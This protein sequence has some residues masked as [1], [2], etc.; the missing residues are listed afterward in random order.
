MQK[1][2]LTT[3]EGPVQLFPKTTYWLI[4]T[5]RADRLIPHSCSILKLN[6]A[7]I[8]NVNLVKNWRRAK[9]L[10]NCLRRQQLPSKVEGLTKLYWLTPSMN[11]KCKNCK[12]CNLACATLPPHLHRDH[13]LLGT[14]ATGDGC[15]CGRGQ[16]QEPKALIWW[17]VP[18]SLIRHAN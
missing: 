6:W 14:E 17:H 15:G 4:S 13:E 12:N 3:Q 10:C 8:P 7:L 11:W 5:F 16:K 9:S 18:V 1:Y 2:V